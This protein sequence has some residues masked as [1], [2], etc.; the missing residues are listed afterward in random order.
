M[1]KWEEHINALCAVH[2]KDAMMFIL[3]GGGVQTIRQKCLRIC[4]VHVSTE[5]RE[6]WRPAG[7]KTTLGQKRGRAKIACNSKHLKCS[8]K[9]AMFMLQPVHVQRQRD[10][11]LGGLAMEVNNKTKII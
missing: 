8:S 7:E 10:P 2:I 4:W 11:R 3:N 5:L 1:G 9:S 6:A